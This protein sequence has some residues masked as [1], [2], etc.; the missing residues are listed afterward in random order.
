MLDQESEVEAF[1]FSNE[2]DVTQACKHDF[3]AVGGRTI[4]DA[5]TLPGMNLDEAASNVE[6]GFSIALDEEL[7]NGV[8]SPC[9]MFASPNRYLFRKHN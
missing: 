6:A 9:A 1:A 4:S 7:L 8:T 3:I 5:S 2:N